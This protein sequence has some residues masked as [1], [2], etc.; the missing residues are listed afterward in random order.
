MHVSYMRQTGTYESP[1]PFK[2]GSDTLKL[3]VCVIRK[4]VNKNSIK[5]V[6]LE[7]EVTL[8]NHAGWL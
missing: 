1:Q 8:S 6:Y 4:K 3:V 5:E 7:V 2:Y